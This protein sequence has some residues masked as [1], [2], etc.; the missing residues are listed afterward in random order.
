M[1]DHTAHEASRKREAKLKRY[2]FTLDQNKKLIEVRE[3]PHG[4]FMLADEVISAL[5]EEAEQAERIQAELGPLAVSYVSAQH[6]KG[7]PTEANPSPIRVVR[8]HELESRNIG[9]E[10]TRGGGSDGQSG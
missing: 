5:R 7:R 6:I 3:A 1:T 4:R 9:I 2:E 10:F 8:V